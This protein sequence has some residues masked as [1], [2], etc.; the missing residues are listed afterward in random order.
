MIIGGL[1]LIVLALALIPS[2]TAWLVMIP[3]MAIAGYWT[4]NELTRKHR[5]H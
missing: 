2:W 5:R 4:T 3:A 1:L